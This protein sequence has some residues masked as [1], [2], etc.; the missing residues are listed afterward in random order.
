MEVC[1]SETSDYLRLERCCK[2]KDRCLKCPY[3]FRLCYSIK[4]STVSR[5]YSDSAKQVG[6]ALAS[7]IVE[8]LG[9]DLDWNIIVTH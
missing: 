8:V 9:S 7:F 1:T 5:S 4:T 3:N 2:P 6:T